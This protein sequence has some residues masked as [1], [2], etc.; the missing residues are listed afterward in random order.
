MKKNLHFVLALTLGL[1]TT[2]SAQD[3]SVDSRTRVNSTEDATST[4]QRVRTA[5]DFGGDAVSAHV[6]LNSTATLGRVANDDFSL[7]VREAYAT[8][9]V[10]DFASVTAGRMALNFGSGRILGDND[11]VNGNGNTWDG[12][13]IGLNND[14]ADVHVGYSATDM[15]DMYDATMMYFNVGK[16]M[17]AMAFNLL[18]VSTTNDDGPA[19]GAEETSMGLDASYAMD[20]GANLSLGYYTNDNGT[21]EMDLTTLGVSYAVNSDLTVMAGYDMYGENGFYLSSGSFGDGYGSGMNYSGFNADRGECTDL[22]FGGSYAMGDFMIGA[23][24][25]T[26]SA[27]EEGAFDD[28]SV[29]DLSVGYTLSDNSSVTLNYAS[30]DES[31]DDETQTWISL[32]I[33]F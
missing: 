32:N 12:F 16:D 31:G 28:I 17:G 5:V 1:A 2:V 29:M 15:V 33:G 21:V 10:M 18:Y 13:L 7:T 20:N 23:T 9:N 25:H 24:M 6:E 27:E 4:D 3:W 30:T 8:T 19:A 11:W 26:I 14:F 22:S